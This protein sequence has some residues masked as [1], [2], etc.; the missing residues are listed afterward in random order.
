M[1]NGVHFI[2]G[3]PRSG[4]TL[5]AA[6][7]RQNPRFHAHMTSPVGS[8]FNAM[9]SVTS[10][11]NETAVF[12]DDVQR[13][14]LLT[15]CFE[16]YYADIHPTKV[17][18]DT[19]RMWT[20]KL[21]TL[22]R[23]F[24]AATVICC[25]RDVSWVLDSLEQLARRNAFQLSGIYDYDAT[26]TVYARTERLAQ[27]G[28]MVGYALNAVKEAVYGAQADRLLLVRYETLVADPLK[29]LSAVYRKIGEPAFEHDP[30]NLGSSDD[31][32]EFDR[33]LGAPGLH[34]I[35]SSVSADHR[36]T[37]LPPDLFARYERDAFWRDPAKLPATV[38]VV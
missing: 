26:G 9:M 5:L 11:R 21:P 38:E 20:T 16:A 29:A 23:L 1:Q 22:V 17:V 32:R 14:R 2:S 18:F 3:L 19:N 8:L 31:M 36:S 34:E 37:V 35:R 28:G 7:L 12:V 33:R 6:L 4:S 10:Q 24:P 15:A 25:V 13:Q 27:A 30:G